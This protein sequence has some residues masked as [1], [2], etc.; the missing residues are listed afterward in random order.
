MEEISLFVVTVF[1][2]G[3]LVG[4]FLN[5]L[6]YRLKSGEKILFSRSH[7]LKCNRVLTWLDLIPVFSWLILRGRCRYCCS[8]I[9]IQYPLVELSTAL[10]F[11]FVFIGLGAKPAPIAVEIMDLVTLGFYLFSAAVFIVVFAYDLRYG[12]IPDKVILPAIVIGVLYKSFLG[13]WE[14]LLSGLGAGL[15][16][17]AIIWLTKGKG[18]GGGDVK[19]G[20]F[21]GLLLGWP[22]ALAGL[23]LSFVLGAIVSLGLIATRRKKFGQTIPFGPFLAV[24]AIM[25]MFYGNWLID[26]YFNAIL[27]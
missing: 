26:W 2:V 21:I 23:Y 3:L 24:G 14:D 9:S 13:R 20:A 12:L 5:A 6:I 7:C 27:R 8:P 1:V 4:S 25:A 17:L 16:F 22:N 19:L 18:M 11:V 10:L 15:F